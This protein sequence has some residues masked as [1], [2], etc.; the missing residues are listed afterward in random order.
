MA[1]VFAEL[2]QSRV[3]LAE[4]AGLDD[5]QLVWLYARPRDEHG[6]LVKPGRGGLLPSPSANG[7]PSPQEDGP[8]VRKAVGMEEAFRQVKRYQSGKA[9][10]RVFNGKVFDGWT[11]AE[12]D[13]LWENY[14]KANPALRVRPERERS[15]KNR[16]GRGRNKDR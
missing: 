7:H 12:I 13:V 2:L 11:E 4:L 1:E 16:R 6:R 15:R 5:V 8:V 3:S 9:K 10:G 14:L